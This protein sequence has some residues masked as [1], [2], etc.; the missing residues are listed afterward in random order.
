MM[1][2]GEFLNSKLLAK[3]NK[4]LVVLAV[5]FGLAAGGLGVGA[6]MES[7]KVHEMKDEIASKSKAIVDA[8]NAATD[9][10]NKPAVDKL[11]TGVA[12]VGLFQT[13]LN[14]LISDNKCTLSQFQASDQMNPFVSTFSASGTQPGSWGQVEVKLNIQGTTMAVIETLKDLDS[15]GIPYE[16]TSLED[17]S[18]SSFADR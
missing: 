10:K 3:L 18:H 17:E 8:Q 2:I 14:K 7:T 6:F 4:G 13:R 5:L 9:A 15:I 1:Y 12:I 11:P 16:F